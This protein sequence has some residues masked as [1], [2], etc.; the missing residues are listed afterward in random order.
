MKIQNQIQL[1]ER[2]VEFVKI[3]NFSEYSSKNQSIE[4]LVLITKLGNDD[5][6]FD[7]GSLCYK[8]R[9]IINR[10]KHISYVDKSTFNENIAKALKNYLSDQYLI[11]TVRSAYTLLSRLKGTIDDLYKLSDEKRIDLKFD[12]LKQCHTIYENYTAKLVDV[13]RAGL[14]NPKFTSSYIYAKKQ[15]IC[16]DLIAANCDLSGKA[17]KEKYTEIKKFS[18]ENREPK[19]YSDLDYSIFL[20]HCKKLFYVFSEF[21][22]NNS[23]FPIKIN[24]KDDKYDINKYEYMIKNP[25]GKHVDYF[26]DIKTRRFFTR[27]ETAENA[28]RIDNV[29]QLPIRFKQTKGD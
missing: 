5:A 24:I 19:V 2:N 17:F 26:L 8:R 20:S 21:T 4:N 27:Y 10:N 6:Y 15:R 16:F 29:E 28:K 12:D 22:V 13:V 9:S 25:G 14:S 18:A 11:F 1:E 7:L 23:F 3:E